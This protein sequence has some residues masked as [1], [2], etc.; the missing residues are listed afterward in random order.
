M[1]TVDLDSSRYPALLRQI[2]H[3]PQRLYYKGEWNSDLFGQC[4]AVVGSRRITS[5]GRRITEQLVSPLASAGV[6]IVSGFMFGVDAQAHQAAVLVGGRTIAVM[7]CGI[8]LIHP[9]HQKR[10]YSHILR[11]KG[12]IISEWEGCF[13]PARWTYP[14][15]NRLVVGL[16]QTT[17]VVEAALG[18]GSLISAHYARIFQR[19]LF[20]V[21]G[22]LT[23]PV[24]QGCLQLIREGAE[25]VIC[26]NDILAAYGLTTQRCLKQGSLSFPA[27][28]LEQRILKQLA[29][30]PCEI[31]SL[32][33]CLGVSV[34][35][36]GA[37]LSFMQLKGV[38]S[39]EGGKYYAC[40]A[41]GH[42]A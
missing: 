15:R 36:L 9:A 10:L 8:D 13:P 16:A 24:S 29:F 31:D 41:L 32:S 28:K 42:R 6:T 38:I 14:Q 3:P 22:P 17:L 18:S 25:M 26:A 33:R 4:L 12:L 39:E 34:S 27:T 11:E 2:P 19:R 1:K 23:S 5:Y 35:G 21:P 20:A 7:P 37:A 30:E 40:T